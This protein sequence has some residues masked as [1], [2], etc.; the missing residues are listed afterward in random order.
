MKKYLSGKLYRIC[1]LLL[2]VFSSA[3]ATE[4]KIAELK[5][6]IPKVAEP[7]SGQA[8]YDD[9]KTYSGF[10]EHRTGGAA[11]IATSYW[12]LQALQRSGID[13]SLQPFKLKQFLN[14]YSELIVSGQS[15]PAFPHWLPATTDKSGIVAPLA[16]FDQSDLSGFIAYLMPEQTGLWHRAD[17]SK[18]VK[19]AASKGALA[20]IVAVPHPSGEI[21]VR[22]AAEPYLQ[23]S[24]P[25]PTLVVAKGSHA[26]IDAAKRGGENVSFTLLGE[27]KENAQANNVIGKIE[28]GD[29]WIIISTPS[30]GWFQAAGERGGGV[31]L[32]LGLARWLAAQDTQQS[33][34][35]VANS[36]HE[37]SYMGAH[38]SMELIPDSKDVDLWLHLGASIGARSW[39][40]SE[41]GLQPLAQAH[42]YNFLFAHPQL[43]SQAKT[44][45]KYVPDLEVESTDKLPSANGELVG[46]IDQGYTA[47]GMVGSHRFFHTPRDIPDV[48]SAELLA[49]YGEAVKRLMLNAFESS[50]N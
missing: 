40:Q 45:F 28:R 23:S 19:I 34:L 30:S 35:F 22:N 48:T 4:P 14:Q 24:L 10:G 25:I 42:Q 50:G 38:A 2:G 9:V 43:L 6:A 5:I 20:L 12:L 21:Y 27:L 8:L 39:Q 31:A 29:R 26:I 17:I 15:V 33:I 1:F 47:M 18:Y 49:P 7:L 41:H 16:Y 37:L 11:D 36:G 13:A 3:L 32:F 46:F 44:A